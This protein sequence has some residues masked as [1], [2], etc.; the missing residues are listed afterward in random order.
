MKTYVLKVSRI[1]LGIVLLTSVSCNK[2][3]DPTPAI[4]CSNCPSP[5]FSVHIDGPSH[6]NTP[7]RVQFTASVDLGTAPFTYEWSVLQGSSSNVRAAGSTFSEP[8]YEDTQIQLEV[9]DANG[10]HAFSALNVTVDYK[11]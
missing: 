1:I 11:N 4:P 6:L 3:T 9:T 10:L 7:A 2:T 8:L 5:V